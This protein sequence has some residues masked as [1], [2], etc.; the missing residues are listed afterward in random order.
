MVVVVVVVTAVSTAGFLSL[1]VPA[2]TLNN[3]Y[4]RF[5][6]GQ[7]PFVPFSQWCQSME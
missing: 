5:F 4:H 6:T 1:L 2:S 3:K 7:L